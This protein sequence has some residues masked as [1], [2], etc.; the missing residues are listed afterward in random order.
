MFWTVEKLGARI[1]ELD[2]YRYRDVVSIGTFQSME[3]EKGAVEK[4]SSE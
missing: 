2:E 3:D 1:Q 4:H